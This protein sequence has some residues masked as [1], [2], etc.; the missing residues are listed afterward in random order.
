MGRLIGK[1]LPAVRRG[2]LA[3]VEVNAEQ[4]FLVQP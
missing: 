3:G 2:C 1:D 4:A